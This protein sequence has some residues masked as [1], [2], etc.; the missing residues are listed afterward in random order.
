MIEVVKRTYLTSS[1]TFRGLDV[2]EQLYDGEGDDVPD[3]LND[4]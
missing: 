2:P 3:Q 4:G 1:M